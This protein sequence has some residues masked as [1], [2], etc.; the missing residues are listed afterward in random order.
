MQAAMRTIRNFG[1]ITNSYTFLVELNM[2]A[3]EKIKAGFWI[4]FSAIFIDTIIVYT[5][6]SILVI[7]AQY[8]NYYIPFELTFIIIALLYSIIFL[9]LKN[10]TIGKWFCGLIV[11]KKGGGNQLV[12]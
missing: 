1:G 11:Q 7:I 9:G 5:I 10:F 6:T 2:D 4:R 3:T 12:Y 8:F